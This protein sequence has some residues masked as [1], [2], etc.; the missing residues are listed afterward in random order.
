MEHASEPTLGT[1]IHTGLH[2]G[3]ADEACPGPEERE[4]FPQASMEVLVLKV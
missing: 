2:A 1:E 4:S 3:A